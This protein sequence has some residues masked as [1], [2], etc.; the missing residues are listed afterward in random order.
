M[1]DPAP[2]DL[3]AA[4]VIGRDRPGIVAA[5]TSTLYE[6]GCNLEDASS[7]ILRGHFAM[8]LIV[9][10]PEGVTVSD[11]DAGLG[12]AARDLGLAITV[13]PVQDEAGVAAD[14]THMVSVYGADQP[15]IV[16][17][18]AVRLSEMGA[19]I[20]DLS[21]RVLGDEA[22]PVYALMLEVAL[23]PGADAGRIEQLHSELDVEVTVHPLDADVL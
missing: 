6:L 15:G 23:P 18:V 8:M 2:T 7:T 16:A 22:S 1:T 5:V 13:A 9:R 11:L 17:R 10:C 19:N 3:A 21:S 14:P 12:A 20:T 4:T